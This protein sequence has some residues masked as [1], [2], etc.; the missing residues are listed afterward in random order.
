MAWHGLHGPAPAVRAGAGLYDFL[1]LTYQFNLIN[2]FAAP[3]YGL[4]STTSLDQGAFPRRALDGLSAQGRLRAGFV[5]FRPRRNYIVQWNLTLQREFSGL[6]ASLGYLGTR[7]IHMPFRTTDANAV[8]PTLTGQGFT[9]PCSSVSSTGLCTDPG[10][11]QPINPT[12]GQIDGQQ[13]SGTSSYHSLLAS[14]TKRLGRGVQLQSSFTWSKSIDITSSSIAGGAFT[15][16]ISGQI[17]AV[18]LRGLSDFHVG[19]SFTTSGSWQFRQWQLS[20]ILQASDG[21][22]FTALISGDPLGMRTTTAFGLPNRLNTAECRRATN[23]GDIAYV[24][25]DC[26]QFPSPSNILGNSSRNTLFGPGL[27]NLDLSV[28]R[29]IALAKDASGPSLVV[30]LDLFNTLNRSNFAAPTEN[31]ALFNVRGQRIPFAGTITATS[32][33]AR[34]L[35]GSVRLSF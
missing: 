7:G 2:S 20:G 12:F 18:P 31:G 28:S 29:R 6:V 10:R 9:W 11:G 21:V 30:R 26:F 23:P 1:P 27:V 34:Q 13:W 19:K 5:E 22:P 4:A 3:F 14:M 15:N 16:S 33:P 32:T 25:T 24:R 8:Q 35:Q 17:F